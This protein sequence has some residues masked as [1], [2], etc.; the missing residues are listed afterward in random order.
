[1]QRHIGLPCHL[2]AVVL[3]YIQLDLNCFQYV[4]H[5]GALFQ[6]DGTKKRCSVEVEQ[7]LYRRY[8]SIVCPRSYEPH[9]LPLR[10]AGE[11]GG[12]LWRQRGAILINCT[13]DEYPLQVLILLPLGYE[14]SALPMS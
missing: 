7:T 11:G 8:V 10:H 5:V 13:N 4:N 9:A 6:A 2:D 3:D 14:P 1:M 12:V